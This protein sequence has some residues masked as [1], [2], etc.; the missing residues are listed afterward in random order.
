MTINRII[1]GGLIF[2]TNREKICK[3][4]N[5]D[6]PR[7]NICKTAVKYL[8]KHLLNRKYDAVIDQLKIPKRQ[9][10]MIY[11]KQP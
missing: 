5:V 8:H 9:I 10:S 7:Q 11:V 3:E 6:T 2:R 4:I 1:Q